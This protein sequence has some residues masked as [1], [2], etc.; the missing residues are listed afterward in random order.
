LVNGEFSFFAN[1][2]LD[3]GRDIAD[4]APMHCDSEPVSLRQG[5][6]PA[7]LPRN[8]AQ[9]FLIPIKYRHLG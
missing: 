9:Y 7:G 1:R 6:S 5:P 8:R 4:E 2:H 3:D